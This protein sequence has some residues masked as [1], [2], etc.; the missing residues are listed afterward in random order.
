MRMRPKEAVA[1]IAVDQ[2]KEQAKGIEGAEGK[3][4]VQRDKRAQNLAAM[5]LVTREGSRYFVKTAAARG[6]QES[7]EVWRDENGRVRCTCAEFE[8]LW[9]GDQAFRCEHILAVKH[10][11]ATNNVEQTEVCSGWERAEVCSVSS[12]EQI[13][14]CSTRECLTARMCS[15]RKAGSSARRRSNSAHEQCTR[16]FSSRQTS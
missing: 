16:P 9:A 7:Y 2:I 1:D 13:E 5:G 14:V 8:R 6:R 15:H 4:A 11:L 10:S 12:A 3:R